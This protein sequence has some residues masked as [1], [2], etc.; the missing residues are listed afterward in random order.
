MNTKRTLKTI[1]I[2]LIIT[3]SVTIGYGYSTY[4]N[5]D[6]KI[7]AVTF[8]ESKD[9][10]NF[11]VQS[12]NDKDFVYL[13]DIPYEKE[14]S[15]VGWG[16]IKLDQSYESD[17]NGL[18]S[19]IVD[20]EKKTFLKGISAHATS[21]VIYNLS[22][23]DFD[24]FTTYYGV[25][26]NRGNLGNG[27][28]FIISTSIDGTNWIAETP[29]T[30]VP[31]KK[32][33]TEAEYI[34]ID[35]KGK[36][37]LKLYAYNNG[38]A[39]SDHAVY[40]GAKL[41]KEGYIEDE[42]EEPFDFIKPI[43]FYD[44]LLLRSSY[45]EIFNSKELFLLQREFISKFGYD[46]LQGIAHLDNNKKETIEWILSDLDA[47]RY[48]ITGGKPT[49]SY[50]SS[51]NILV[52]LYSEYK[53]DLDNKEMTQYTTLGDLYKRMMISL[54][55]THS[56][57]VCL[58]V[59]GNQCS[60]AN[61]RY[62]IYK[63]MQKENLLKNEVFERLN[64]E[65]MRWVM[66][67]NIDDEEIEWLNHHIRRY[68]LNIDPY[69]YITYRSGYNYNLPQYYDMDKYDEW[70]EKYHLANYNITYKAG[71]PKL[72]IVFEQG[73][74]CGGLSKTGSNINGS[75]G[76]PS[77]V[78]GQPG[79][80]AYLEY[81]QDA[82]S[83]KGMWTIKND[84]GGWTVAEKGERLLAD[85][86]SVG[87][88]ENKPKRFTSYYNVVYVPYAQEALNDIENYNK[89]KET[90]LLASLYQNDLV[91][92]EEIY[93]KALEYQPI[94]MDAWVGLIKTYKRNESKTSEDYIALVK[95]LAENMY[96]F[97]LPM[98][99]LLNL[100]KPKLENTNYAVTFTNILRTSLE[101]GTISG[102]EIESPIMQPSLTRLMANHLLGRNDYSIAS[103]SFDGEEAN[104]IKLGSR[105]EGVGVRWEYSLDS[106]KTWTATS[107]SFVT[108][109]EE[110]I[111]KITVENDIKIH[112][113]GVNYG[114]ENIYTI[115]ITKATIP[116]TI[117]KNDLENRIVGINTTYEWRND[118]EDLWTS[119]KEASPNNKGDKTLYVRIGATGTKLPSDSM[120]FNFTEDD[121][122]DTRKYIPVSHLSIHAVSS[123]ATSQGRHASNAIDGNYNT[124]WHS[125]WN[126]SDKER[127]ITIKLDK[128]VK[129][130]SVE[131][132]PSGGGNG[133]ILDGTIY[134][135]MDGETWEILSQKTG[136][137]YTNQANTNEDAILNTKSFDIEEPKEVQYV[138]IVANRASNG[139]WF[140]A[141]AFNL[142]QDITDKS[143]PTASV[144]YSNTKP[145]KDNVIAR[146]INPSDAITITSPASG[147]DTY[148]FTENGEFKFEFVDENGLKG[149]AL[150]KVN[151]IDRT[152]PT[153]TIEYSTTAPTNK[154]VI[155]T[156][157]PSEE[158]IVLNNGNYTLNDEGQ[159]LNSEG[160]VLEGFTVD[161]EGFVKDPSGNT[162]ANMNRLTYEFI[163]NGEF[164]FHYV[165]RAG[166]RG[167]TKAKVDWIDN[168]NSNATIEYSTIDMT[169][170]DVVAKIVF[171]KENMTITNNDGKDTYTFT[172]NGTFSFEYKDEAGNI[173]SKVAKVSWIDKVA[174]DAS[175]VYDPKDKT[176]GYVS[177][178]ILCDE[179]IKI[180]NNNGL[181]FYTFKENGTFEFTYEDYLGNKKSIVAKVDWIEKKEE[182]PIE[183]PTTP[184]KPS[185]PSQ[186]SNTSNKPS[187]PTKKPTGT[188]N[189]KNNDKKPNDSASS[190]DTKYSKYTVKDIELSILT[191]E[192]SKDATLKKNNLNLS[193]NLKEKFNSDSD[194][195]ELY[196]ENKNNKK[197]DIKET[198]IR[199]TIDLDKDK[200]F[201]GIYEI[202]DNG[203]TKKLAY[204]EK[205]DDKIELTTTKLGRY[206]VYYEEK[207]PIEDDDK[208][209]EKEQVK[210]NKPLI[211][212]SSV[213]IIVILLA[214][215][216][217]VIKRNKSKEMI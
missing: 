158:V 144:A 84:V 69:R 3:I 178:T 160:E 171:E 124:N 12:V 6:Y 39:A 210:F 13:S 119:Y 199:L 174:P 214:G 216:I 64:I 192:V 109:S 148:T 113:V 78:I 151:W 194:Y 131:Y 107:E 187:T 141:R 77:A 195:F 57:N 183:V 59:G 53:E 202:S 92:L 79:H 190:D 10:S 103:F 89:A 154:E 29:D 186:G 76:N 32:G 177:A 162:I 149:E 163:E 203:L 112:I 104:K 207:A 31:I 88:E 47:L 75:L 1:A 200:K 4:K 16:T 167:S 58:W 196:F 38:N 105:Y 17:N 99:D 62:S 150:A 137:T 19:L 46:L 56:T 189:D 9:F 24:Y 170:K 133:K 155:A 101:K 156:L 185:N 130:S 172:E 52:D 135:S 5:M 102:T 142:Y 11:K 7:S 126:G 26:A 205:S 55:L 50:M 108:L 111:S 134:G 209:E 217:F 116:S 169:N 36:K 35:I 54:S 128:A 173:G 60:D 193:T 42:N 115:D 168:D 198:D 72:W 165:D 180:T 18:I 143:H 96:Y 139:N 122:P 125:A 132:V 48:Y 20:G 159:I 87:W 181:D 2:F 25:D 27:V 106:G 140:T 82:A 197:V 23:L 153:A 68:N 28:K 37:Y 191:K 49:G 182:P 120:T 127:Y 114:E 166:N 33:N 215:I 211:M 15:G 86:G 146:L 61:T 45:Q 73:S 97:P 157:K 21:T 51:L 152:P 44:E 129:I 74:V 179:A 81:I 208:E 118:E 123:Q 184:S 93:R 212:T 65:E 206:V 204:K 213:I 136:L 34:T 98:S 71:K 90:M 110:E 161:D 117:F 22:E 147:S 63:H 201:R 80:A 30:N 91:K 70:N 94:N 121:Q 14:L 85:W 176:T 188:S 138:K 100:I 175:I 83:G 95:Y 40:A 41:Y 145:T 66:N 164:T 67:N 8:T 43:N